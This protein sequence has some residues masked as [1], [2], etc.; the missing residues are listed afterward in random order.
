MS[1]DGLLDSAI[2]LLALGED[3]AAEVFRHLT[4]KEVQRISETMARTR[5]TSRDKLAAVLDRFHTD[6]SELSTLVGNSDEYVKTVLRRALGDE[7]A[8]L[9]IDRILQGGDVSGI[10]SLKWMDPQSVAELIRGEHPQI[11]ASILVHLE[12]E[13]ASSILLLMGEPLRIEVMARI[14]TLDGIQPNAL[15]ELNDVLIT[16][17]AGGEKLNRTKLGGSKTAAE[18]LNFFGGS[19][20]SV[21]LDAIR[22]QDPELAQ[23]IADQMFTFDDLARLDDRAMQQLLREVQA[24]SLVIGLKGADAKLRDKIFRNMSQRAAETLRDDLE[25]K[26]PVKVSQVEAEQKEILKTARRLA[27]EGLISLGGAND[28]VL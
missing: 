11:I 28:A 19:N 13:Q 3:A 15:R 9:L 27:D 6:S 10:E 5:A 21:V 18:I 17:L 22:S 24:D 12:R 8:G 4:P 14:A 25:S 26:G 2:L 16:L 20:E 7:K 1:E 23:R